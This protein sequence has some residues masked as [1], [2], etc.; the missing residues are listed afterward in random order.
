MT[1]N[2]PG[3][4]VPRRG[5][6]VTAGMYLAGPEVF[7]PNSAEIGAAKKAICKDHG[8]VGRYPG[9]LPGEANPELIF[10]ALVEM[11]EGSELVVANMT[12]FR[13]V[14]I[15]AGTAME[16]GFMY[17]RGRPVFGYTNVTEDYA[18]RVHPDG[19]DVELFGLSDNLMCVAPS[20]E[21]GAPV[22]RRRTRES[23]RFTDMRG[24]EECVRQ[25]AARLLG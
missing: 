11:M 14:S 25:A 12:P 18:A 3:L 10:R 7:L 8:F 22:V 6:N 17:A 21:L 19:M 24:F 20:L 15:D 5:P 1:A 16:I 2:A 13:G 4:G 9:D 23:E